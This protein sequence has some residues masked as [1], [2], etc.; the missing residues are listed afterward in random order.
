M[1]TNE[2]LEHRLVQ[3]REEKQNGEQ[4]L[5]QMESRMQELRSTLMRITGA[6]ILLEE[7]IAENAGSPG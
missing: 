7:L 3:L 2:Q 6:I 1:S 4:Q 5:I